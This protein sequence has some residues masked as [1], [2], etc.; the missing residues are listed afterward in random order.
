MLDKGVTLT[1]LG[2]KGTAGG[3]LLRIHTFVFKVPHKDNLEKY[4]LEF[5]EYESKLFVGKFYPTRLS[6]NENRF[7]FVYYDGRS[8]SFA[9]RVLKTVE[10]GF[11]FIL[12]KYPDA[13]FGF[14]GEPKDIRKKKKNYT[15]I[16]KE[17]KK[18][19]QR[20]RIYSE[21]FRRD[22]SPDTLEFRKNRDISALLFINMKM[23]QKEERDTYE[24]CIVE[25]MKNN[26]HNFM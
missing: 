8:L 12:N 2:H 16:Q 9:I 25:M 21:I 10:D 17:D 15:L 1:Y 14:I 5:H 20:Y 18:E 11:L 6:D 26:Y 19:S 4:T 7:S 24:S 23:S 22:I 3:D 13:S